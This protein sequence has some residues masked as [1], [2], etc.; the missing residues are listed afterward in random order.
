MRNP[1][2]PKTLFDN[3]SCSYCRSHQYELARHWYAPRMN[4]MAERLAKAVAAGD[5]KAELFDDPEAERRAL[6]ARPLESMRPA[7]PRTEERYREVM[8]ACANE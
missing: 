7:Q 8:R 1:D 4:M 6:M 3:A 2:F 5:R